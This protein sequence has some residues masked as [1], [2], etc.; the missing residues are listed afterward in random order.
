MSG[1]RL[2]PTYPLPRPRQANPPQLRSRLLSNSRHHRQRSLPPGLARP[3]TLRPLFRGLSLH[4]PQPSRFPGTAVTLP[5]HQKQ[6]LA[7]WALLIPALLGF[8]G[9]SAA[10]AL[11]AARY[12][13][14]TARIAREVDHIDQQLRLLYGPLHFF[15]SQNDELFR[16][17]GA[18][19]DA[20]SA[21]YTSQ[22]FAPEAMESVRK[23]T[24]T[25]IALANS[26]VN[27]VVSNN[28][29]IMEVLER[30]WQ[31][32]DPSDV[33]TFSHFQIDYIR[34]KT[35]VWGKMRLA[36]PF[37]V[38]ERIGPISYMRRE[39][40]ERV[41]DAF[42]RKTQRLLELRGPST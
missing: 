25:T 41:R 8:V 37:G 3:L 26:Y 11:I 40:S 42:A 19:H 13:A 38:Y 23:D 16:L 12:Q 30:C 28:E 31:H 21:E 24:K 18:F 34:F 33:E 36:T 29:R 35:E 7:S 1:Y 6:A 17:S 4:R 5:L 10:G 9:G 22:E 2:A 39:M 20:Y 27:R 32:L 15:V 14:R